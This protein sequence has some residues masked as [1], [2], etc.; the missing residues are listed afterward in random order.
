MTGCAG[1]EKRGILLKAFIILERLSEDQGELTLDDLYRQTGIAKPTVFRVL[2][3]LVQM[4]YVEKV[5]HSYRLSVKFLALSRIAFQRERD[6]LA[7][8]QRHMIRLRE[9][10]NESVN[11]AAWENGLAVLIACQPSSHSF[12]IENQV[13]QLFALHCTAIGKAIAAQ[14]PWETVRHK[15]QRDGM[16]AH[17]TRTIVDAERFREHI[18]RVRAAGLA[19]DDEESYDGVRCI[20]VP[21][22]EPEGA[23]I[24]GM[25]ISGPVSR[26][27]AALIE[28]MS[29][30][31]QLASSRLCG[32]LAALRGLQQAAR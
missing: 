3:Q 12:R 19:L 31:L 29:H 13:G 6:L 8:A 15:L 28:R 22:L 26:M 9:L 20:A 27:G 30:D 2:S 1:V 24:G 5:R 16:G 4:Q 21:L 32:D 11:L 17:T 18:A 7:L 10:Y 25:S 23:V 14:L